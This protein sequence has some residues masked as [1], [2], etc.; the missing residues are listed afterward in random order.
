MNTIDNGILLTKSG[1]VFAFPTFVPMR[2]DEAG[3]VGA[4]SAHMTW[5]EQPKILKLYEN[6]C[7]YWYKT[8]TGIGIYVPPGSPLSFN[9]IKT[10]NRYK[11]ARKGAKHAELLMLP[12]PSGGLWFFVPAK[13]EVDQLFVVDTAN[14]VPTFPRVRADSS[15]DISMDKLNNLAEITREIVFYDDWQDSAYSDNWSRAFV[16]NANKQLCVDITELPEVP[17]IKAPSDFAGIVEL[18]GRMFNVTS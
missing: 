12:Y 17:R 3:L 16:W 14:R 7:T 4:I 13:N 15:I 6:V 5:A 8:L 2:L 11:L 1:G 18:A 9:V 10:N